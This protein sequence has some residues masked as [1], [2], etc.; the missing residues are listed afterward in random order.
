[1]DNAGYVAL[2]R[3]SGL[4]REIQII[5]NNIAN[6]STGGFRREGLIF[7]EHVVDTGDAPSLSMASGTVRHVDLS[8]AGLTATGGTFDLAISGRGFFLVETPGGNRLTRAGAFTPSPDGELV[9]PDGHRLLDEAGGAVA[10]PRGAAVSIA[11]DGTVSS[12][13]RPVARI[14]LWEPADPLTL[15]YRSGVMLEGG[16]L[17]PAE[18]GTIH[19]GFLEES[20]VNPLSEVARMVEVQRAYEMGQKFLEAED[21]RIRGVI[22]TLGR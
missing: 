1:M 6:A 13:G 4:M 10:V 3:Q 17:Q 5:A 18:G 14:G 9:N 15:G 2:A 20:N 22:Q 19:Q 7:A 8:Q 16:E 11:G 12:G 21:D